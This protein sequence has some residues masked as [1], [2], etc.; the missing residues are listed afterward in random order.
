[1]NF[2][3]K[4]IA[5]WIDLIIGLIAVLTFGLWRP[6]WD[7][8]FITWYSKRAMRKRMEKKNGKVQNQL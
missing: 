3:Y 4:Y 8:Q 1:M 7:F 5:A 2:W 6:W